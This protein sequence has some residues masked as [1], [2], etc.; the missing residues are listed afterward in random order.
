MI[1]EVKDLYFYHHKSRPILNGLSFSV[2][3][4]SVLCLL[5]PNGTG[6]TTLIRCLLGMHRLQ[7][8][9]IFINGVNTKQLSVKELSTKI[10]YVPQSTTAVF[11]YTVFD[12]VLMGRNPHI[13]YLSAPSKQD[14]TLVKDVLAELGIL[15]LQNRIFSELSG[16]EK[17]IVMVA[18]ALVQQTEIIIM[19]EPTAS[20]DYGNESK[21]LRIINQISKL[22]TS[23][24]LITHSPNHAFLS[25]HKVAIMEAGKIKALG[26]PNE[27]ITSISLSKLYA[28]P[29]EVTS[30]IIGEA[31]TQN[32]KVCIPLLNQ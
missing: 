2:E 21:I 6:K 10:A 27:I 29:I 7:S 26:N 30:A 15:Q 16:G 8:G 31:Q 18:R 19:D 9:D 5:G 12:M 28:T 4:G 22:G 3:K 23:I 20:L 24:I 25:G 13:S 32:M 14:Q 1:L 11:P 17:Q